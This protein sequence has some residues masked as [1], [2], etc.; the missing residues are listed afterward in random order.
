MH[1]H[2]TSGEPSSRHYQSLVSEWSNPPV[3]NIGDPSQ[4]GGE[5][6]ELKHLSTHEE[7]KSY[8]IPSVAASE[9]GS[10]LNQCRKA[11]GLRDL[12]YLIDTL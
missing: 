4:D 11:L 9:R 3:S 10:S 6:G 5:P 7:K 2:D 8:E 1:E 12:Q